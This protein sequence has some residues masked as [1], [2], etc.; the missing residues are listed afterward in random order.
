MDHN[1]KALALFLLTAALVPVLEALAK[2]D[3]NAVL[4]DPKP[5]LVGL[6][7]ATV[8]A[9]ASAGLAKLVTEEL[10]RRG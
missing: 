9:A 2:F 1:G 10:P 7:T 8:R 6:L 5:W 3:A 4:A